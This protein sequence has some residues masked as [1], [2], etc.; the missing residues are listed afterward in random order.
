[1]R[2]IISLSLSFIIFSLLLFGCGKVDVESVHLSDKTVKLQQND[3]YS[4][5]A[6]VYPK[7]SAEP[8]VYWES[9]DTSVVTV[10]SGVV[11]AVGEGKASVKAFTSNGV[12][13][14]CEFSV[15]NI[16]TEKLTINKKNFTMMI[17]TKKKIE[18]TV[19]PKTV[20]GNTIAWDSSNEKVATVDGGV[21][22]AVGTGE[23]DITATSN[24]GIKAKC[25]LTVKVKPTG[26][27]LN[28]HATTVAT[29]KTYQ[30]TADVLPKDTA[31]KEI[32][33]ESSDSSVATV[34]SEGKVKGIRTGKCKIYATTY[35]DKYDYCNITVTQA[36]LTFKGKGNKIL[37]NVT[38]SAG[39]Y[40]I[41]MTH[42]GDG[43]FKIIGSDGDGRAY[44]YVD[45][46]G[47]YAGTNLYA[48]GKSDGVE[49]ATISI[50]AT[51]E[52]TIKIKAITYNGTDNITGS[53]ECVSPMFQGTN[54]KNTVQ[55]K[56]SEDGDFTVFLF[57]QNG[58]Q[59]GVLC[60]ELD[61]Y[62]GTVDAT[63][64]KNKYYFIVVKSQGEWQVDFDN[65]SKE[66]KVK[67][68]N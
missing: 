58:K 11:T 6:T 21:V 60:D 66:T 17:G 25:H 41:T 15:D 34:D 32:K 5:S 1:M 65:N 46:R 52:W 2:R 45:V 9:S 49:N 26:V 47:D 10:K 23:C 28:S 3:T 12:N 14:V 63:L 62:E 24:N 22:K 67:N 51:G 48:K 37:D 20:S 19:V 4:L 29:G 68:T 55:L 53:G 50:S 40:A 59:I 30:L 38:V 7:D 13:S 43:V 31:Y 18:Y 56:N 42:K 57:D 44:T 27:R 33:W 16:L 39:V 36:P 64:D 54:N 8:M 35:N 61:D